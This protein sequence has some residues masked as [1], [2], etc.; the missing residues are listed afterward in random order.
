MFILHLTA[1]Y[2][3]LHFSHSLAREYPSSCRSDDACALKKVEPNYQTRRNVRKV[4][5]IFQ[6]ISFYVFRACNFSLKL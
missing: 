5:T 4:A 6:F 3:K 2:F 1:I